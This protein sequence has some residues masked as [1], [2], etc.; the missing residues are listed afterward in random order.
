M[1]NAVKKDLAD[2]LARRWWV[3]LLRGLA[4]IVFAILTWVQPGASLQ[5][6]VLLFGVYAIADGL[7]A[8]GAAMAGRSGNESWWM[9]AL[10]GVMGLGIGILT[11]VAPGVTALALLFYI[12]AWAIAKGGIEIVNAIKL[13]NEIEG[14]WMFVLAGAASIVFGLVLL[15]R[16]AAGALAML[17]F[18]AGYAFVFGLILVAVA[19]KARGFGK[20]LAAS[21]A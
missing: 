1:L 16:P 14:E 15:A 18:I 19:F 10:A 13:R 3:M 7:L 5:A 21:A 6:L 2:V 17:W 20:R 12:G 4:A 8:L 9:L 11:F